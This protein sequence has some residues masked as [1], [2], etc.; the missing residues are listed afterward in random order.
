MAVD[1]DVRGTDLS[2]RIGPH[3]TLSQR[4]LEVLA[5]L[6]AS[7]PGEPVAHLLRRCH[8][9]KDTWWRWSSEPAFAAELARIRAARTAIALDVLHDSVRQVLDQFVKDTLD[10]A[11]PVRERR[12]NVRLHLEAGGVIRGGGA[13]VNV[14]QLVQQP[15]PQPEQDLEELLR[16][17]EKMME[18][19]RR[20]LALHTHGE[21]NADEETAL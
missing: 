17:R 8:L 18:L 7:P 11:T 12:E 2:D 10:P 13:S 15:E 5:A 9:S 6:A 20:R 16:K 19:I 14:K 1:D 21:S 4:Q 3:R